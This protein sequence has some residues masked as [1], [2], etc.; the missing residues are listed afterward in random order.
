MCGRCTL[1]PGLAI[2]QRRF[3]FAAEE[4]TLDPRYNLAPT[5]EAPVVVYDASRVLRL[6]QWGLVPSWAKE[7]SIG[8]RM[9]NARAETISQ[10]PSFKK[11]FQLGRCLVLADG[12]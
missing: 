6:M 4:I 12:F 1:T 7:D 10:K 3:R 2:L 9:I 8:N 5:Q 11:S